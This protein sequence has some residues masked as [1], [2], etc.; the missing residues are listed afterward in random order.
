MN[1]IK[2]AKTLE[3]M[4]TV[5]YLGFMNGSQNHLATEEEL[6]QVYNPARAK[7]G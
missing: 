7:L 2:N 5:L 3:E 4:T 6:I 1:A